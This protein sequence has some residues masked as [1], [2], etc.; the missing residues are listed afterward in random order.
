M[1]NKFHFEVVSADGV[2]FECMASYV[3][4]PLTD[5]TAGF[6]A[7]HA[8][9]LAALTEGVIKCCT[10]DN[11]CEYIAVSG[12][13]LSAANN[14][15]SILARTAEKA[16]TI[17]IARAE[18]ARKRAEQRLRDKAENIDLKRAELSL[19]RAMAREKAYYM[20]HK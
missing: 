6:L 5:G 16:E 15:L 1:A 2:V 9:L 10:E 12:G 7:G 8:P 4:A 17:D 18:S 3:S 14:E 13:V 11:D 19:G 20:I